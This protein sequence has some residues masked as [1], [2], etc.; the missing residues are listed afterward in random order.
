M[1]DFK[2][3]LIRKLVKGDIIYDTLGLSNFIWYRYVCPMP[4]KSGKDDENYFILI[5]CRVEKPIRMYYEHLNKILEKNLNSLDDVTEFQI[6]ETEKHLEY[7]KSERKTINK[8]LG[9]ED[10]HE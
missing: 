1:E 3:K 6:I 7:L 2:G 10:S 9:K 5:D 8:A 4:T